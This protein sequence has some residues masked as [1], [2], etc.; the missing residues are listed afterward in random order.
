MEYAIPALEARPFVEK[1]CWYS[2][3]FHPAIAAAALFKDGKITEA[4]K[5]YSGDYETTRTPAISPTAIPIPPTRS[6]T[7]R[8]TKL[9]ETSTPT[10]AP[11]F[12]TRPP[13]HAP[14]AK[15]YRPTATPT[16][17]NT[18]RPKTSKFPSVSPSQVSLAPQESSSGPSQSL[19]IEAATASSP[20]ASLS[21]EA[22]YG[23][24]AGG[25]FLIIILFVIGCWCFLGRKGY[26]KATD[27][28]NRLNL[29]RGV[30]PARLAAYENDSDD[31]I[32]SMNI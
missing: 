11:N 6:P 3:P 29:K 22:L 32:M 4:G 30:K 23:M 26:E 8:P 20:F 28:V 9:G 1:Y 19:V 24:L 16:I 27:K 12:L 2:D 5:A 18:R 7:V 13:T 10:G 21:G 14:T 15:P 31:P 25:G 17:P